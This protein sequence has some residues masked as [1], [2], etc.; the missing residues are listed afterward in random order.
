MDLTELGKAELFRLGKNLSL[1][2]EQNLEGFSCVITTGPTA[3]CKHL[4]T[5]PLWTDERVVALDNLR[6]ELEALIIEMNQIM[7]VRE[8]VSRFCRSTHPLQ[9]PGAL[10]LE[11]VDYIIA[12]LRFKDRVTTYHRSAEPTPT[13]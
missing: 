1:T 8:S 12:T 11:V 9:D 7:A 4:V 5:I 2:L 10:E 13:K 3:Q 6:N